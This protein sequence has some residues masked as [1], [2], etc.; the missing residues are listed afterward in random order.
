MGLA[1][2]LLSAMAQR[3]HLHPPSPHHRKDHRPHPHPLPRNLLQCQC[4][5]SL[6][7][8]AVWYKWALGINISLTLR[9][10]RLVRDR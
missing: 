10:L 2:V 6:A 4:R 5:D 9:T 1:S 8:F 7:V 3:G